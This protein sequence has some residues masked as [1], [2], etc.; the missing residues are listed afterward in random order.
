MGAPDIGCNSHWET[1][2]MRD[3]AMSYEKNEC[4]HR[5]VY[6]VY[7]G[8][9]THTHTYIHM[10]IYR[11]KGVDQ[12]LTRGPAMCIHTYIYTRQIVSYFFFYVSLTNRMSLNGTVFP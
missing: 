12:R 10:Y 3:E 11:E 2:I 6:I 9:P 8:T 5:Y 7:A 4:I 1:R